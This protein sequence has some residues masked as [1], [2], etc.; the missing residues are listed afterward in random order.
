MDVWT[1]LIV[2]VAAA[3]A[4]VG[5][6]DPVGC[7]DPEAVELEV[8]TA[9]GDRRVDG[10]QLVARI[11]D[12][13]LPWRLRLEVQG[14]DELLW[15]RTLEVKE[16]DCPYLPGLVARS[17]EQ[18]LAGIPQ[19]QL[20]GVPAPVSDELYLKVAATAP[21]SLH[22]GIG[23]GLGLAMSQ[24][25]L[26]VLELELSFA[27]IQPVDQAQ[28]QFTGLL[29]GAGGALDLPIRYGSIR[30][31]GGAA[32]GPFRTLGRRFDENFQRWAPRV[33]ATGE[34]SYALPVAVRLGL[35]L[36]SPLV[37]LDLVDQK[38]GNSSSEP[39]VRIGLVLSLAGH[40]GRS[41]GGSPGRP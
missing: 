10:L 24:S 5:V 33:V 16:A 35:R 20:S 27:G 36:Q 37:R 30:L 17:V 26:F 29:L 6:E 22:A 21:W 39:W 1:S 40:V 28:G 18:G 9:L 38:D 31:Q 15:S 32:S 3:W 41:E 25:A 8:R 23:G 11:D 2:P 19:W 34:L 12:E 7:L 4:G 13:A 14:R